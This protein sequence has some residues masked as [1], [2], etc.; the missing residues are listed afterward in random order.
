MATKKKPAA[1]AVVRK[2][3]SSTKVI[4]RIWNIIEYYIRWHFL[5]TLKEIMK[6]RFE[7]IIDIV[8]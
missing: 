4:E 6:L 8:I 2:I 7:L 5:F 1:Y 3:G